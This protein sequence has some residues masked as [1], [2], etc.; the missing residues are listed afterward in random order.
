MNSYRPN[1]RRA[2]R[3]LLAATVAIV[4]LF[5]IDLIFGGVLR[6]SVRI[7]TNFLWRAGSAA[8][9]S[10]AHSGLFA[11]RSGL[12]RQNAALQDTVAQLQDR[13]AAYTVLSA[14]NQQLRALVHLAENAPGITAPVISS[15]RTSPYG[16]FLIGAGT[17]DGVRTG[18]LVL[19]SDGFVIG[20]VADVSGRSALVIGL[21]APG[22]TIDVLIRGIPVG[23]KGEG[24][25]KA[26]GDAPRG[27]PIVEGDVVVAPSLGQRPV[28]IV[29]SVQGSEASAAT[30]LLV[31][32]PVNLE[33]LS[34]VYV[35]TAQ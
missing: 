27:V 16:T 14:E 2:R 18:A 15:F 31:R 34:F 17:A 11:T 29:G 35:E 1:D 21:F 22:Q 26:A 32:V 19:T 28:G 7:G 25:G 9:T 23:L 33:A 6:T 4:L 20:H 24:G 30:K 3:R 12:A 13:A 5:L 10:I 8:G